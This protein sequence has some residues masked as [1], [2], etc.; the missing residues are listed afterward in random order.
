MKLNG[1]QENK[2]EFLYFSKQAKLKAIRS[3]LELTSASYI[4]QN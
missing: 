3:S 2:H 4:K 1:A